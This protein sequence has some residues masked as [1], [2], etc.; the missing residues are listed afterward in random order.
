MAG[1]ITTQTKQGRQAVQMNSLCFLLCLCNT[2]SW[3]VFQISHYFANKVAGGK[4]ISR[5]N[6]NNRAHA[7]TA[8]IG[9]WCHGAMHTVGAYIGLLCHRL[10]HALTA[11]Y[12]KFQVCL[13]YTFTPATLFCLDVLATHPLY[14]WIL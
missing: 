6:Q 13:G 14:K 7:V 10:M 12:L 9:L 4:G 8:W 2:V 1:D 5:W 11:W 3:C